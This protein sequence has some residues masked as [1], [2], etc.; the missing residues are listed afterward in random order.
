MG[1][2]WWLVVAVSL[3]SHKQAHEEVAHVDDD[4][5]DDHYVALAG[6][7]D[8]LDAGATIAEAVIVTV[9]TTNSSDAT[10]F[11]KDISKSLK[12][13]EDGRYK[14]NAVASSSSHE[15]PPLLT[16]DGSPPPPTARDPPV[17]LSRNMALAQRLTRFAYRLLDGITWLWCLGTL[18]LTLWCAVENHPLRPTS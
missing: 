5:D 4:D 1:F 12:E 8:G 3:L 18:V 16:A 10:I 2:F 6:G 13:L 9:N 11:K 15:S 14:A 7:D 17:Q